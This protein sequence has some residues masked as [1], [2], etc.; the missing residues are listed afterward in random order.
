ME[1]S[2]LHMLS[3]SFCLSND[4][5]FLSMKNLKIW[6]K[7]SW[8]L[9]NHNEI[10]I[11]SHIWAGAWSCSS[12]CIRFQWGIPLVGNPGWAIWYLLCAGAIGKQKSFCN[13]SQKLL[14]QLYCFSFGWVFMA[15]LIHC[16]LHLLLCPC[17]CVVLGYCCPGPIYGHLSL[18]LMLWK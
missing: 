9:L 11:H 10:N 12:L 7:L 16:A 8:L 18:L 17:R 13:A 5:F 2:C 4:F 6:G 14:Q 15:T 3:N 1:Q